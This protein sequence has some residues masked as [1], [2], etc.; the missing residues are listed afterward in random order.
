MSALFCKVYREFVY[1]IDKLSA[2][3]VESEKATPL[4]GEKVFV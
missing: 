4:M 1:L 3:I 2:R